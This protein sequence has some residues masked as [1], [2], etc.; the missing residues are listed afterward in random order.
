MKIAYMMNTY[1][2]VSGT[3]IGREIAALERRGF[4]IARFALRRWDQPLVDDGDRRE[5]DRTEY[6]LEAGAPRLLAGFAAEAAANP[7]GMA[8]ALKLWA[9]LIANAGGGP[10]RHA[11]YLLEAVA[12]RRRLR[13]DPVAHIHAH[14]STNTAAV[15]LLTRALGG[16][17]Y[18]FTVHGPDELFE[19]ERNSLG[20]KIEHAAFV[21]CISHFCRSQCMIFS[22]P[23]HWDRLRIVHCGVCP[24]HY[25]PTPEDLAA[26]GAGRVLFVGRM[27]RI[28]GVD[29]L[30]QAFARARDAAP[31]A[32]LILVGDGDQRARLERMTHDL[33]LD[34]AAEFPGFLSQDEVRARL[35][36]ADVLALASFAEGVPVVLMEAQ[37]AGVPVIASRIAGIEELVVDGVTGFVCPAGDVATVADRLGRLLRDPG[38]RASMGAAGQA[39]VRADFDIDR[40]ADW[41]SRLIAAAGAGTPPPPGL[42]PID[43]AR[44]APPETDLATKSKGASR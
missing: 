34:D 19:P 13:R 11:A 9:R 33:G 17:G 35:A 43:L 18:S 14:W 32:R 21:A 4:E 40:E 10:A 7:S 29:V 39:A 31:G 5:A 44:P 1:P 12:L 37:A 23:E 2:V 28:K 8:R 15:C 20:L 25:A 16:P 3:F 6:L 38:L 42:R 22:E 26:R 36:G 24:D 41:L 27:S 30:L